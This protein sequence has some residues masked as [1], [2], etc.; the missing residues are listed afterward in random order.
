[1]LLESGLTVKGPQSDGWLNRALML[2]G[3]GERRLGLA[4][5]GAV[6]LLLRGK[7]PVASYEPQG[8]RSLSP[9][10]LTTLAALYRG[11]PLLGP[12]LA[13]GLRDEALS[14]AVGTPSGAPQLGPDGFRL[15]AEGVGKLLAA[16]SGPRLAVLDMG[17]WDTHVNEGAESGRLARNFAG[18]AAGLDALAK[19]LAPVWR[20]SVIVVVTEFGRTVAVNGNGGTD[21]GTGSVLIA[22]GGALRGGRLIGDWPGLDLLEEGRDLRMAT[23][24]RAVMKGI[25]RDHLGL[26]REALGSRVFPETRTLVPMAGLVR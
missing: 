6:P 17:G 23:D 19:S 1:D 4:V 21:H 26:D 22:L 15:L 7:V 8:A 11:D 16:E 12:A 24:S 5:G 18:L 10:F 14:N 20:Q 2:M 3:G 13:E 25:L 9:D